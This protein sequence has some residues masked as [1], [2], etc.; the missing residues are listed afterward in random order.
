M[1]SIRYL[2]VLNDPEENQR[3][4][5]K[6]PNHLVSRWSRIVDKS[7]EEER[8]EGHSREA[9]GPTEVNSTENARGAKYPSF[10]EF[11]RFLKTEA[12]IACNPITS[13]QRRVKM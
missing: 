1:H 5:R 12:R 3:I 4:L 10:E 9:L 2:E 8:E 13:L 6:L 11:C 7:I